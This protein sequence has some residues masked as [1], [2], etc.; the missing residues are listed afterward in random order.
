[1]DL[2][3]TRTASAR[4]LDALT[5]VI[6]GCGVMASV[7]TIPAVASLRLYM[8]VATGARAGD[9]PQLQLMNLA[10]SGVEIV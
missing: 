3:A 10:T 4:S 6:D 2:G 9:Y 7:V 1:M 8:R 5:D